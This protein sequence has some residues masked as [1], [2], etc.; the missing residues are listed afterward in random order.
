MDSRSCEVSSQGTKGYSWIVDRTCTRSL[1]RVPGGWKGPLRGAAATGGVESPARNGSSDG[2]ACAFAVCAIG[3]SPRVHAGVTWTNR[4]TSAPWAARICHT[5]VVDAAGAI[6]VLGG[7]SGNYLNDVWVGTDRG[8]GPTRAGY[9]G[10]LRGTCSRVVEVA[11]GAV[12]C[13][14]GYRRY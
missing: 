9:W 13:T 12:G 2:R 10:V 4:T 14:H 8:A 6:Y 7:D 11:R 5:S 1:A 3:R